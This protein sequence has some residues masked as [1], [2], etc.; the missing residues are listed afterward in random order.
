MKKHYYAEQGICGYGTVV[1]VFESK[2]ERNYFVDNTNYTNVISAEDV[3]ERYGKNY[4][5]ICWDNELQEK[6]WLEEEKERY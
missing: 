5:E 6:A 1:R 3:K 2:K 4:R